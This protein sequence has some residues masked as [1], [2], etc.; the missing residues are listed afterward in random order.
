MGTKRIN[1]VT[2]FPSL[3]A[4][5]HLARQRRETQIADKHKSYAVTQAHSHTT[6]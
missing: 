1:V 2:S 5:G 6:Q 4:P 3:G